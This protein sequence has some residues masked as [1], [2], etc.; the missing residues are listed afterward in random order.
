MSDTHI[1]RSGMLGECHELEVPAGALE[2]FERGEGP[3]LA[4]PA[5]ISSHRRSSPC[6]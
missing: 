5:N 1:W 6:G 3:A 4:L 2:Y